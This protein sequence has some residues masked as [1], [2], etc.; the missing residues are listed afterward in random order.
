MEPPFQQERRRG[1]DRR[2]GGLPGR[3]KLGLVPLLATFAV[4]AGLLMLYS[5]TQRAGKI[6]YSE[7]RNRIAANQ[8]ERVSIGATT[9]VA[10]PRPGIRDS[11][12]VR[13]W[14]AARP[15]DLPDNQLLPLLDQHGVRVEG[16]EE[17]RGWGFFWLIFPVALFFGFS[18]LMMRRMNPTQGVLTVGKSRARIVG[19]EGTGVTFAD[20]AGVDEARQETQEIV[21][22]LRNPDKFA[23]L[24]AKIPKGVL[25]VGPPG[26]GKTLLARAVA[27]EAGVT[28]FQLSGAEFVEMF[29]G[30][31]AARVRDLFAQAKAQAPCIIFI[32]ELDALGKARTPGGV[33][34]GNDEREQ[35]LNQL[36]VEMDGFDPRMAVI[37]MA[38]TNR[39]EILDPALLRPG[40]FDRQILVDRPDL[41][42]RLDILKIHSRGVSMAPDVDLERIARRTPGFVGADLANLLNE[43]ALLAARRDKPHVTMLEIDDAVDRIVAGLEKKNRLIN[44]KERKI[45][46]Y[47][48]AGHAVVAERVSTADPVHKISII[49]RGVAALGYTQQLPTEDRYLLTK[50]ELM[51]RIAVLLGGRVAEEIVFDEISTGA[52]NDLERV[53]ELARSMVMEYGMSRELGAVNLSGPRRVQFLQADGDMSSRRQY[54]EETAREIDNE[55]RGL[56]AGTYERVRR[57]LTDDRGVLET[58]ALRLL[59]KEVVDE[60]ELRE[61]MHLPPRTRPVDEDRVVTPPPAAPLGSAEARAAS[62]ATGD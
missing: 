20:V 56:I 44:A 60:A 51:D 42:G 32:D 37:I 25:L 24:G 47:H 50:Q 28:F 34:G 4:L 22:F 7:L 3:G 61:I 1:P 53:T 41:N 59:E 21:E 8:V 57:I 46:A 18:M 49:P 12:G 9:I 16:T 11:A 19:E 27:G 55:I 6:D 52:G 15:S 48:E 38:A 2:R 14:T 29:V 10:Y 33:L 36:L 30:V 31:G 40:R 23:A 39:P 62:S 17:G 45:V 26:T 58:L 5:S 54:S 13:Q 35:T 43:A